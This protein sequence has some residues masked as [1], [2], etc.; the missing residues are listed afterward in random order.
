MY[1]CITFYSIQMIVSLSGDVK[2]LALSPTPSDL[3]PKNS[4]GRSRDSVPTDHISCFHDY[5]YEF[6]VYYVEMGGSPKHQKER[7]KKKC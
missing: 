2:P 5:G 4:R 7:Q 1:V 6:A 3:T